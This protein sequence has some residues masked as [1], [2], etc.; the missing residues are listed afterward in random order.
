MGQNLWAEILPIFIG[1]ELLPMW[2]SRRLGGFTRSGGGGAERGDFTI[3]G[4]RPIPPSN[5][6]REA[7]L[8]RHHR[9]LGRIAHNFATVY[10]G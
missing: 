9:M 1:E 8:Y 5:L 2:L 7:L 3:V 10:R 6:W 4:R